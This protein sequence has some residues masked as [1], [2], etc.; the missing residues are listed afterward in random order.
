MRKKSKNASNCTLNYCPDYA[1]V[2]FTPTLRSGALQMMM[3]SKE[4]YWSD[5]AN[6]C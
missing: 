6:V 4:S 1:E 5:R 3:M 2:V